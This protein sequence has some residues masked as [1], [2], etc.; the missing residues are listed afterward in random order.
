MVLILWLWLHL[1][2]ECWVLLDLGSLI[3]ICDYYSINMTSLMSGN[4]KWSACGCVTTVIFFHLLEFLD[5]FLICI[6]CSLWSGLFSFFFYRRYAKLVCRW[7]GGSSV[8]CK[9][10]HGRWRVPTSD[11]TA[12]PILFLLL[13][14]RE[15]SSTT[16]RNS[17]SD[18]LI[19]SSDCGDDIPAYSY[20]VSTPRLEIFLP[21]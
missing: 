12:K 8:V 20:A 13:P 14:S 9:P 21:M 2:Y 11:I 4:Q 17:R 15:T 1:V 10:K 6:L 16:I 18:K 3:F 5:D 19:Q 7:E